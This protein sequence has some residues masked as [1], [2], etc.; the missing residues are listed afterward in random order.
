MSRTAN[1]SVLLRSCLLYGLLFA[2]STWFSLVLLIRR[3]KRPLLERL[4]LQR[5]WANYDRRMFSSI[6]R[7]RE[8][9]LGIRIFRSRP[10]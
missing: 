2:G 5:A 3:R 6:G 1:L 7:M 8:R 10:S 9:V 4:E